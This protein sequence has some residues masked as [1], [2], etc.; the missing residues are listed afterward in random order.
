MTD[1][2][3][4]AGDAPEQIDLVAHRSWDHIGSFRYLLADDTWEWSDAVAILH[5]YEPGTVHPTVELMLQ[6]KHPDDKEQLAKLFT[7]VRM[8]GAPFSSRHRIIDT[9]GT[10]KHVA[11]VGSQLRG[12][13]GEIL[14][15]TG[16]YLDVTDEIEDEVR[17]GVD[18]AVAAL[19]ETRAVIDQAKG[20]LMAVYAISAQR[21]FEVLAWR[22]Q[23][24]NIKLRALAEQLVREVTSGSATEAIS[25]STFDHLLMTL[26]Q[27]VPEV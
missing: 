25:R 2:A 26:H 1:H 13:H 10:V 12:D 4:G 27:R 19:A 20:M 17:G 23:E 7:A 3:S 9:K 14:G 11:V 6:H 16:F 8:S 5:G 24:T 22:S 15:T 21:A 18:D